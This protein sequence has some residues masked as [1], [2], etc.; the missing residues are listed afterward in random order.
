MARDPN[1]YLT[2]DF[3]YEYPQEAIAQR[4]LADRSASRLLVLNRQTGDIEHKT[5]SAFSTL[6]EPGDVLVLNVSRVVPARLTGIRDNGRE[7]EILLVHAEEDGSWI[8]LAHPGGKLKVGRKVYFGEGTTAE[9]TAVLGGGLRRIKFCG[10]LDPTELMQEFGDVPLPPYITRQP[11]SEDVDRYQTVYATTDGSVAAPTAGLHFTER[12][13]DQLKK[14]GVQIAEVL[15]H[16]GP[17]TFKPVRDNDPSLHK[18]HAE[19][20]SVSREAADAVNTAKA[21]GG[22]VWAIG[23]TSARVL[24]TVGADGTLREQSG[25]TELFILPPYEFKM[26]D[27]MLTNFH[28]PKS[29]LLMLVAAFSEYD[30]IMNAYRKA[31]EAGYRLY[32]YGDAMAI[33]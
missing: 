21:D 3:D 29:T 22:R 30:Q 25:W 16:V 33:I 15:L 13:L 14:R 32:S 17:G 24:E 31:V 27:A 1:H 4:P 20:Y 12:T 18:M 11:E 2:D 8:C 26:V 23:T 7:A 5:F 9:I 19:W 10:A 28:L 6:P